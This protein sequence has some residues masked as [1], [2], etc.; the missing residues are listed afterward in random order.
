MLKLV[1]TLL[2][3]S[4]IE[5]G[6]MEAVYEPVDLAQCT[7]ELASVFRSAIERAGLRLIVDCP[8]LPEP[9]FVDREMWEKIVLN[10]LSNA[11]KF[12]FEGEITLS[13]RAEAGET[14]QASTAKV[15][16]FT[17]KLQMPG[18]KLETLSLE[19]ETP[20]LEPEIPS[21]EPET[22][23]LELETSNLELETS[24]LE[25]E[26]PSLELG[27]LRSEVKS[28]PSFPRVVLEVRDTGVGILL[29]DLPHLFERFYQV[30]GT[31]ARTHEGSGIGLA[32]VNELV[33]LHGGTINVS[34][35][36][37]QG[38][39]FTIALFFGTEHLPSDR[40][41][42]EGDRIQ[43]TRTLASTAIDAALC[44]KAAEQWAPLG[45]TETQRYG[46]TENSTVSP[47]P[48]LPLPAF[49][50]WMTTPICEST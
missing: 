24:N 47:T 40:L 39:C 17:S 26:T 9:V 6:R 15:D 44:V 7:T 25:L 46:D 50:W 49:S 2:N 11:F 4:R 41:Q 29:D 21:L 45:S 35:T 12:T 16:S 10:L 23:N 33:R 38:T 8:P 30:R 31:Q 28:S 48:R 42:P 36:V 34:S 22:S 32:L 43:P 13:I 37:G 20:S 14:L 5:A 19:L 27:V 3:F 18:S 1:N